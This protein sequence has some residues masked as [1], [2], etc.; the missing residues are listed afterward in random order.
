MTS[1][2]SSRSWPPRSE[3]TLRSAFNCLLEALKNPGPVGL[4]PLRLV[5]GAGVFVTL[6]LVVPFPHDRAAR[7]PIGM[8]FGAEE[9]L[10]YQS[11]VG[12]IACGRA[13]GE[14]PVARAATAP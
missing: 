6:V 7:V 2:G 1:V 10:R 4:V 5:R 8:D 13:A 11:R 12:P 14:C 3:L 9:V